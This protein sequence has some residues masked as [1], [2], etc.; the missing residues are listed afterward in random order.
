MINNRI[1][2]IATIVLIITCNACSK[3]SETE[4]YAK[5]RNPYQSAIDEKNKQLDK[6]FAS[7]NK[8]I[9]D[10]EKQRIQ[11]FISR[12]SWNMKE[13]NGI[14]I[15]ETHKGVGNIINENDIVTIIYKSYYINGSCADDFNKTETNTQ[16]TTFSNKQ[17][18]DSNTLTFNVSGDT[19]V[20]YGL[21]YA[22]KHLTEG[23]AARV[24]VP[25]NLA[26]YLDDNGEKVKANATLIYEIKVKKVINKTK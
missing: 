2:F 20:V 11:A 21:I 15:E 3:Q 5:G 12:R 9:S 7:A 23:S 26:F 18:K 17:K 19:R 14:Y 25:D 16:Q 6:S 4:E 22:V 1:L 8:I 10:K 24:I 13:M